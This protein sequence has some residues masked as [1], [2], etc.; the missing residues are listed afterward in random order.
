MTSSRGEYF[1][2]IPNDS[3]T[4]QGGYFQ[5]SGY[6]IVAPKAGH[7]PDIEFAAH[8]KYPWLL[9]QYV[10]CGFDYFGEP[11]P[12]NKDTVD[13][14]GFTDP[15]DRAHIKK[16]LDALGGDVPPRSSYFGIVDLCGFPKDR[17]YMYQAHW[18][19]DLPMAHILPH[20]NWPERIGKITPVHVYTSGDEAELFLNGESLGRKKKG[21]FQ[22]RIRWDETV[23]EPGELVVVAYKGG[24]EWTRNSVRTTGKPRKL[25]LSVDRNRISADGHDLAFVTVD[26]VDDEGLLVPR[27]HNAVTYSVSGP[28]E[29]IAVASG[30]PVSHESFHVTTRKVFNGKALVIIRSIEGKKGRIKLVAESETLR[31]NSVE[32]TTT[33]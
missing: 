27:T 1:F 32:I 28:G 8:E 19:P 13:L 22:Y 6:D 14:D 2:P 31:S 33:N 26:V 25:S 15:K 16:E 3:F 4:A 10:W 24:K 11:T 30:N 23:Y 18:R 7:S 20:W 21:A 5:A 29:I 9:G 12:Y 17:Y